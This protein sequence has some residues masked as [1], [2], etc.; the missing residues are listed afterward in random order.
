[1][2]EECVVPIRLEVTWDTWE[3]GGSSTGMIPKT[4]RFEDLSNSKVTIYIL[5]DDDNKVLAPSAF[6][7]EG[8]R[9]T[10]LR[11]LYQKSTGQE[12]ALVVCTVCLRP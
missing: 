9:N 5:F 11:G 2:R 3:G 10:R 4:R 6:V 8:F 12:D 1:M 7:L